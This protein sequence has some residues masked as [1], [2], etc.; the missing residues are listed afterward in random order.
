MPD[1]NSP[2]E[3]NHQH[4]EELESWGQPLAACCSG[5]RR[6]FDSG[7]GMGGV[8]GDVDSKLFDMTSFIFLLVVTVLRKDRGQIARSA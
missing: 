2:E 7:S 8:G 4:G 5:S 6:V 1:Q 3:A